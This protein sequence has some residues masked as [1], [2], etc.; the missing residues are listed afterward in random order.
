M[1]LPLLSTLQQLSTAQESSF[2]NMASKAYLLPN[3][4]SGPEW[5]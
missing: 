1:D 2:P 4:L 5:V 3:K